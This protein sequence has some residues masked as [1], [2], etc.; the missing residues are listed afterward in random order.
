MKLV[1]RHVPLI[2]GH[3]LE[4]ARE[5]RHKITGA[6]WLI[7]LSKTGR[8]GAAIT[9]ETYKGTKKLEKNVV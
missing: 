3:R 1:Y 4:Y 7:T 5:I 2:V 6:Q 9:G 8:V